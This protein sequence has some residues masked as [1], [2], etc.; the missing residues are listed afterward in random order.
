MERPCKIKPTEKIPWCPFIYTHFGK[1]YVLQCENCSGKVNLE[2]WADVIAKRTIKQLHASTTKPGARKPDKDCGCN[3]KIIHGFGTLFFERLLKLKT[4]GWVLFRYTQC[5]K[6]P[7][8]TLLSLLEWG[9]NSIHGFTS[10][11]KLPVIHE[12]GEGKILWCSICRCCIE[13]KIRIVKQACPLRHWI[14]RGASLIKEEDCLPCE[15][16]NH[17]TEKKRCSIV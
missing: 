1:K 13:A 11:K 4:P 6:C 2:F 7:H 9:F 10:G 3:Q 14:G 12:T 15:N 8:R 16:Q 17:L 5:S